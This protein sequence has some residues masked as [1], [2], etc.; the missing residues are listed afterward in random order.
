MGRR[1]THLF[2]LCFKAGT[3]A[4]GASDQPFGAR[5][6]WYPEHQGNLLLEIAARACP[7]AARAMAGHACPSA[8][9]ALEMAAPTCSNDVKALEISVLARPGR[10]DA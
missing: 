6:D 9:R 8:G 4:R 1:T 3:S 2:Y 5:K 7:T 10:P